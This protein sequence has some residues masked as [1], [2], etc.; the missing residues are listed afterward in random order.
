MPG[1]AAKAA[2]HREFASWGSRADSRIREIHEVRSVAFG[3]CAQDEGVGL[4][5]SGLAE[6]RRAVE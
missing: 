5:E 4:I 2:E 1:P 6:I 3:D